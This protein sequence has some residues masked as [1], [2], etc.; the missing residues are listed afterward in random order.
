MLGQAWETI[1][2]HGPHWAFIWVSRAEFR[3][4][5]VTL[6]WAFVGWTWPA[7][8]TWPHGPRV[9]S[10]CV[11]SFSKISKKGLICEFTNWRTENGIPLKVLIKLYSIGSF[12]EMSMT[13]KARF[14][15]NLT[16]YLLHHYFFVHFPKIL[17]YFTFR[18]V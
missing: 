13:F 7:G 17:G 11:M 4:K 6:K 2:I 15:L 10:Y 3:A 14:N 12:D 1:F 16:W 9:V 5:F 18:V 8:R